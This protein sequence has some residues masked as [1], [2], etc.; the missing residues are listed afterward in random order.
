[1]EVRS[2]DEILATLDREGALAGLPFMPEMLQYTGKRFRVYKSAHKTCDTIDQYVIRRMDE[3]V[4]L[5]GLRCDGQA[6]GG[7]QAECLLF[8]K[9]AWL[10]PVD[11]PL[12]QGNGHGARRGLPVSAARLAGLQATTRQAPAP[13][14]ADDRYRC[15]ATELLRATSEVRGRDRWDPRF[16]LRDLTS[17]N[18]TLRQFVT[19]GLIAIMNALSLRLTGRRRY[20]EVCGLAG[21]KTPA[22]ALD[23]QAGETVRVRSKTE[24]MQTLNAGMRNRGLWFDVEMIPHC[25]SQQRVLRRVETI[26]DEK[27]GRL[28][29]FPNP[30][31]ILDGVS[32]S[33]NLSTYRMFCPRS[34]YPY[35]REIWLERTEPSATSDPEGALAHMAATGH[36]QVAEKPAT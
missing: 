34:V 24:I 9:E 19:Y 29:R 27:T 23:L 15:Q 25:G 33:G 5:E 4:H 10:K 30:C 32:C 36:Q 6:H 17:G 26:V 28:V 13:G 14:E 11:G 7:C 3:T 1:M 35:W 31:I 18:V 12:Q 22:L 16:Y 8:W 20:P 21:Q 2:A